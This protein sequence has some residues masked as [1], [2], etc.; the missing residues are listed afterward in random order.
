MSRGDRGEVTRPGGGGRFSSLCSPICSQPQEYEAPWLACG[1]SHQ[2]W[3][4]VQGPSRPCR[5]PQAHVQGSLGRC[6]VLR[7]GLGQALGEGAPSPI[8]FSRTLIPDSWGRGRKTAMESRSF[9]SFSSF[10]ARRWRPLREDP[11]AGGW[12]VAWRAGGSTIG[13]PHQA[14]RRTDEGNNII[15]PRTPWGRYSKYHIK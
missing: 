9:V 4:W 15:T 6:T 1:C 8:S 13:R 12:Q 14:S 2:S 11:L 3:L 7:C 10:R 5:G